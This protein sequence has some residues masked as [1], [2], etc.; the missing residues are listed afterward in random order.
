MVDELSPN[1]CNM[2]R[3]DGLQFFVAVV[4]EYCQHHTAIFRRR[5]AS[6]ES[7]PDEPVKAPSQT[8]RRDMKQLSEVAHSKSMVW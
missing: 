8:G 4:S 1:R 6:D 7:V 5:F 3:R 2:I